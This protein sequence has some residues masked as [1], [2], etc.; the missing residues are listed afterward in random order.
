MAERKSLDGL[1]F[2]KRQGVIIMG[3]GAMDIW[4]GADLSLLR[5]GL[6]KVILQ[7]K[8][9]HVGVDMAFVK[10]VPSGFFG[11]LYDWFEEGI[12]IRLYSPQTRVCNMLWFQTFFAEE[13]EGC[14][15][16]HDGSANLALRAQERLGRRSLGQRRVE[17]G[18]VAGVGGGRSPLTGASRPKLDHLRQSEI[19]RCRSS[20]V[21]PRTSSNFCADVVP[22]CNSSCDFLSCRASANSR[23]NFA[24]GF[25]TL[26]DLRHGHLE[27]A[28]MHSG[29]RILTCASLCLQR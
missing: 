7:D 17:G 28:I 13:S 27:P 11:M 14:F 23:N 4:D 26:S 2:R 18:S 22:L 1:T 12:D 15:V 25:P 8:C 29:D 5:D 19:R 10:Y 20:T 21:R 6:N 24:I 9:L 3:L 16:L